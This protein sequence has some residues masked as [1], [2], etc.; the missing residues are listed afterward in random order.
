M[1]R[2]NQLKLPL[3]YTEQQLT[4]QV[5]KMLRL[6]ND[7]QKCVI[8]IVK[9]SLDCRHKDDIHYVL[10][11]NV[12]LPNLDEKSF[13]NKLHH[14]DVTLV[15]PV[16]YQFPECNKKGHPVTIIGS[17]PA[18]L[19][20][21]LFLARAGFV[22]TLLERGQSVE[23]RTKTVQHFWETGE[24]DL[25]TN[26]QFGEGGAGTF[27]DGKLNTGIKDPSGRIRKVLETFVEFGAGEN[28]LY[29]NKPHVGT[30]VL[31]KVVHNISEEIMRLGSTVNFG[32]QVTDFFFTNHSITG[33]EIN[34]KYTMETDTVVLALG[35]SA[36][37]TFET[38]ANHQV[39]ME[40][41]SFAVGCRLEHSQNLINRNAYGDLAEI[42][43]PTADYKVTAKAE[44][45]RGVFSFCMC[46]G[47]YV[48]NAS[49]EAEETCVNGMSYAGR[50]GSNANSAIIVTVNPEDFGSTDVLAGV[51]FQRRLEKNAYRLC[52]GKVPY[53]L[54]E[55][56]QK[57][58]ASSGFGNV[59]PQIKGLYQAA[60]LREAL[61]D[62]IA[63]SIIDGMK[64]F[65]KMING[66]NCADAV[67][68]G[69]ES[70]TSSPIRILRNDSFES[71]S[72]KGIFPCG[73]GAGYAGGITS[74][75]VDG[76]RVAEAIAAKFGQTI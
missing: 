60:N 28:I 57:G 11:V 37:D 62:Y 64:S 58:I 25:N 44:N 34:H 59:K 74:A 26:I 17:G 27:S 70:R 67:F 69:V 47:G 24:L 54:N 52:G 51:S 4:Q 12:S 1:I 21:A 22:V 50:N 30:D 14:K 3:Q 61:P 63:E 72:H 6:K 66:F 73:E 33:L 23:N 5:R 68:S 41:K 43:L 38:L 48:V 15:N 7:Q 31:A 29:D 65:D 55:D 53:Q 18:G 20:A 2:I 8:Q 16:N 42:S 19:F 71:V 39:M 13:V 35:H 9:R 46:P 49:S 56:F 40:A 32:N 45:G 76:I 75:A 10:S 36:R